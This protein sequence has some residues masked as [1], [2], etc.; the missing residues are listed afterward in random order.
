MSTKQAGQKLEAQRPASTKQ[1]I[2]GKV[3][4]LGSS[5]VLAMLGGALQAQDAPPTFFADALPLF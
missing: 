1:S 4:M 5:S 2:S 3:L